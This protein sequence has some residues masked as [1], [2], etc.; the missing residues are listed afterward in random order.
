MDLHFI[1]IR[2]PPSPPSTAKLSNTSFRKYL[3]DKL[4]HNEKCGF[5]KMVVILNEGSIKKTPASDAETISYPMVTKEGTTRWF[6]K[7]R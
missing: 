4:P 3:N 2:F 6:R 5:Y 1:N 7:L